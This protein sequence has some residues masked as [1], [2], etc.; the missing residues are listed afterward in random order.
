MLIAVIV[1]ANIWN[2]DLPAKK[3]PSVWGVEA[4]ESL[5]SCGAGEHTAQEM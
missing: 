4:S 1:M 5:C 3:N 2:G